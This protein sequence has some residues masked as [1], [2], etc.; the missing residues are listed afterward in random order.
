MSS[1]TASDAAAQCGPQ[2]MFM[3]ENRFEYS[4]R[5]YGQFLRIGPHFIRKS[6]IT[7]VYFDMT[8]N[9]IGDEL[10]IMVEGIAEPFRFAAPDYNRA[11][12]R[13][14]LDELLYFLKTSPAPMLK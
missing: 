12:D 6:K 1:S 8:E 9:S 11:E 5:N 13:K 10:R 14:I 3:S 2:Y 7:T 4:V